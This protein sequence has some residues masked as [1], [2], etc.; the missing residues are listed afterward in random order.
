MLYLKTH[1]RAHSTETHRALDA[2][3]GY[4]YLRMANEALAEFDGV[5]N[6]EQEIPSVMLARIRVLLH[7]KSWR[8]AELLAGRGLELH[9]EEE[10]FTVQRV[11]A[12]H[13]LEMG[14]EAFRV[15][16]AAPEWIRRTGILHYNLACYEARLGDLN[17]ARRCIDAAIEINGAIKKNARSDPDLAALWN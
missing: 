8:Q 15:L 17:T 16:L 5:P 13:Q 4:L 9:P 10:E 1:P 7:L 14:E 11:F 12:L 2:A 6:R 3:D